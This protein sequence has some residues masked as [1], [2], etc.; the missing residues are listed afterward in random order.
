MFISGLHNN[1]NKL[2]YSEKKFVS[3]NYISS[4]HD[5][6]NKLSNNFIYKYY[7]NPIYF[8]MCNY[9]ENIFK[10]IPK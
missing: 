5:D 10:V 9:V 4:G 7:S 3:K 1:H 2:N 8:S 6:H